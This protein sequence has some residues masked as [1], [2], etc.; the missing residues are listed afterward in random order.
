MSRTV[1]AVAVATGISPNDLLDCDPEV[2]A[3]IIE[4]LN[5]RSKD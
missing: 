5:D 4:I 1:A 3:E 2:F